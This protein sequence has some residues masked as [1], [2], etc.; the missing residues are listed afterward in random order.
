MNIVPQTGYHAFL[1]EKN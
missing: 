1:S